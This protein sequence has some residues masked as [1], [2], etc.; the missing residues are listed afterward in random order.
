MLTI[1]SIL[2]RSHPF[3][4][5]ALLFA[6]AA[7]VASAY[8]APVIQSWKRGLCANK[9]SAADFKALQ[10]GV[11]WWYNWFHNDNGMTPSG[12]TMQFEPMIW[13]MGADRIE[14]ARSYLG[15]HP[16]PRVLLVLNEPNLRG[17]GNIAPKEAS[18]KWTAIVAL[19][20]SYNIPVVG[21][22][23]AIGAPAN[24]VVKGFD[25]IQGKERNLSYMIDWLEAFFHYAGPSASQGIGLHAY[26]NIGE[27]KWAVGEMYK[28]YHKPV[29][30]TEFAEWNAQGN[31]GEADY[32]IQAVD[33]L[34][35]SPEVAG[36]AWFKERLTGGAKKMSLLGEDGKL[37]KL[38]ELYVHMPSHDPRTFYP[39]P[40]RVAAVA[41]TTMNEVGIEMTT[42]TD[43]W[44]N[45][46]KIRPG[47]WMDYQLDVA[48][49][50]AYTLTTRLSSAQ[51]VTLRVMANDSTIATISVPS[52]QGGGNWQTITTS[53][54][55]PAG[56][57]TLRVQSETSGVL[58]N[59]FEFTPAR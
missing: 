59:W 50:G 49:A 28:K 26:G 57:Q 10:P 30:V 29:W 38:G 7:T 21:P 9:L 6:C 37:T 4:L 52:P 34:E 8:E 43:G 23:M 41:D 47:S 32:M 19:A 11:S 45:V 51:P 31:Y 48:R 54:T 46:S 25:P 53:V 22:N 13:N 24:E 18:E 5:G 35:R 27:L 2:R 40:G 56:K 42:D 16:K 20:K 17:Q 44:F 36:Y 55:L 33:F 12:A 15:S 1:T 39:V 14:G 58:L 3:K